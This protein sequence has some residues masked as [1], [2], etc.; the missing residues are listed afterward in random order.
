M[1]LKSN[2]SSL[3]C[4]YV[5]IGPL[6]LHRLQGFPN[7]LHINLG[8]QSADGLI[9]GIEKITEHIELFPHHLHGNPIGGAQHKLHLPS[10]NMLLN[11]P[12]ILI[13]LQLLK[14]ALTGK[15]LIVHR[16]IQA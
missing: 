15:D 2:P 8:C 11:H 5:D 16:R 14:P 4:Q 6:L 3:L 1:V 7:K 9:Q 12:M 10:G 13:L